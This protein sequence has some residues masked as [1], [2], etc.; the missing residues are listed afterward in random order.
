MGDNTV[1]TWRLAVT[2]AKND[3]GEPMHA[4]AWCIYGICDLL[5]TSRIRSQI[6]TESLMSV[7][8]HHGIS[9]PSAT[10]V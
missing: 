7:S 4:R 8:R 2:R 9:F 3:A 1:G 5:K 10:Y 6:V